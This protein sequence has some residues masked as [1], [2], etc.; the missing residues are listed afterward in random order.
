MVSQRI[1]FFECWTR[2][3]LVMF[4]F[5]R[6]H[7]RG[8]GP[9]F[10]RC[11]KLLRQSVKQS[12]HTHALGTHTHLSICCLVNIACCHFTTSSSSAVFGFVNRLLL[13]QWPYVCSACAAH[14]TSNHWKRV[15]T[16]HASLLL[17]HVLNAFSAK[18]KKESSHIMLLSI[19]QP[20]SFCTRACTRRRGMPASLGAVQAYWHVAVD[21]LILIYMHKWL[22]AISIA[23]D[24]WYSIFSLIIISGC[25][26]TC[27][28]RV[29]DSGSNN[30]F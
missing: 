1:L 25:G 17:L 29:Y 24:I 18:E 15:Y 22:F 10:H 14:T 9:L 7:L 4:M 23:F 26:A 19:Y 3:A 12:S 27:A 21:T 13:Q 6:S 28:I 30:I 8:C 20:A 11:N 16:V 2:C 5:T